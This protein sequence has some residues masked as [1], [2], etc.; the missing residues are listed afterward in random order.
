MVRLLALVISFGLQIVAAS[1]AI[2]FM[3]LTKYRLS[4]IFLSAAFT[5][6]AVRKVIQ[7][8]ELT[9]GVTSEEI[10]VMD[11]WIGTIISV[12]IISGVLFIREMF[13]SLKRA[14]TERARSERRVLHAIITTEEN[15]RKRFAKD[16][17]DGLG[18]LLSTVKMSVSA[19]LTRVTNEADREILN[20]TNHVVNEA[21]STIKDISNILSPHILSNFGLTSA[22]SSF[23]SKVSETKVLNIS[24]TS[25]IENERF[26]SDVEVVLYR[27]ICEL[28]NNSIKHSGASNVEVELNKHGKFLILQFNDNGRGFDISKIKT[29]EIKG[30]GLSNIETRVKSVNG[31]F[32]IDSSPGKGIQALIR[33][34]YTLFEPIDFEYE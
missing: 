34:D 21:I 27:A 23:I 9:R 2:R 4:W 6:M 33:I 18:P 29:D 10:A 1:F 26:N 16:L 15:E 12:L 14:E 11:E 22:A 13:I 28:V 32:L 5:L 7:L 19:L 17:H 30:M 20:N 8:I 3:K 31:L 25:N 24:F